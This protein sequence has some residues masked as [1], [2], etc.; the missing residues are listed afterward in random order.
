MGLLMTWLDP[1]LIRGDYLCL[2][3]TEAE[4]L[5]ELKRTKV[6]TPWPSFLD[7]DALA[8]THFIVTAKG[9]RVSFVCIDENKDLDSIQIAGLLAHESSHICYEYF[10]FIGEAEPSNEFQAYAV[11]QVFTQ[12]A[13]A[14]AAKLTKTKGRS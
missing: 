7:D 5:K 1:T 9:N 6:P 12:L 10:R 4:F 8:Q 3:T 2:C 14:Y 13:Y 11:Q